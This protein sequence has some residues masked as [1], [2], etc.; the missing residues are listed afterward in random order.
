[1]KK[2]FYI[3]VL[4]Y[5]ALTLIFAV[6]C[7]KTPTYEQMKST[8]KKLISRI[9]AEYNIEILDEYPA[10]GVFGENQFVEL[11]SGI[12][13]NV[14][15]SGNGNRAIFNQTIV[16]AR[17]SGY[18]YEPASAKYFNT[19]AGS[20]PPFEFKYG[21]ASSVVSSHASNYDMYYLYFGT[22]METILNYVGENAV[23]KMIVPGYAEIQ[24][25]ST[26]YPVG[27]GLQTGGISYVFIPI[28]YDRIRYTFY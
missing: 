21:S 25:G 23:I 6:S 28:Y 3:F 19:F 27:S 20:F 12:F 18:Y 1:M 15:D 17:A 14:V 13:L 8:E 4:I 16:L 7:N 11:S 9:I 2:G 10:D 24:S 5:T 22:G 26:S